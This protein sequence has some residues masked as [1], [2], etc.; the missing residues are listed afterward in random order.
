MTVIGMDRFTEVRDVWGARP[1]MS[2]LETM[3]WRA[4]RR[5][6][7]PVVGLE[8]LDA[9]PDWSRLVGVHEWAVRTLPRLRQG[10]VDPPLGLG[11]PRWSEDP[12]F[13]LGVHLR[14]VRVPDGGGW[15]W[16]L[17]EAARRAPTPFDRGRPPWEAVLYEGLPNGEAA[18]LIRLHHSLTDGLGAA[19]LLEYLHTRTPD[20][21]PRA[22]ADAATRP[23][24]RTSGMGA[25]ADQ[26]RDDVVAVSEA[27]A[28]VGGR[29]VDVLR[30][31]AA[32]LEATTRYGQSLYR[33]LA[34]PAPG[35][36][37]LAHRGTAWTFAALDLPMRALRAAARPAGA[38]VHDAYLAGL[39]GGYRRYHT[40]LG[41]RVESIPM[42]VPI[43]VR[44]PG[45]PGGG[46]RIS[47]IRFSGPV[48][49]EDPVARIRAVR[50]LVLT[51][52]C[53]PA[54]DSLELLGPALGRMPG[55]VAA[56]LM[57]PITAGNDLQ[58][59]YVP[60]PRGDRFLAG[61]RVLRAYPFAPL[62]GCPAMITL[63]G[64]GDVGCV[65]INFDRRAFTRPALFLDCLADGF[66]EV[67]GVQSLP[68]EPVV[69]A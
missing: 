16:L 17:A 55:A 14:R 6:P 7:A 9:V 64:R 60:G 31:P 5:A 22:G 45:E 67:L 51:A 58:A 21:D 68:G 26:L 11:V 54:R 33:L 13:D 39:L 25:L 59:S 49:I 37:L 41:S 8:R 43:S 12:Y 34:R 62:P 56:R 53:E 69:H 65:G 35:S 4:D 46:N 44:R 57:A 20:P 50:E 3:M 38:G 48:G 1:E 61:A 63:V 42:A 40:A 23:A 10:V 52:R 28:T 30:D 47:G 18:Y 36:P 2:A 24:T 29:A 27:A 19:Q 32:A 15:S 66:R